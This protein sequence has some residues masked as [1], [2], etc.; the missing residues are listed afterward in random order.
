[1]ATAIL[2]AAMIGAIVYV[3]VCAWQARRAMTLE[4]RAEDDRKPPP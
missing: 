3:N 2:M 1:M 4:E